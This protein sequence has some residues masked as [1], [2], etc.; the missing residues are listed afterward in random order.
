[1]EKTKG[2]KLC[3]RECNIDRESGIGF[4]GCGSKVILARAALHKWE[5]PCISGRNGS[6]TVFFSGCSLRCVFCQNYEISSCAYGKTVDDRRLAEIFLELQE[7]KANNINLVTPTHFVP[8]IISALD[9]AK[10]NGL[11]IP[12]VY[13]SSGYEKTETLAML[14]GYIDIYLPD[15]KYMSRELAKKYSHAEDYPECAATAVDEMVKQVGTPVFNRSNKLMKKGVI[16][17]HLILPGCTGDSKEIL[18]YLWGKYGD[19]IYIS[20]MNQFTPLEN[21][22][23]FPEINRK[24]TVRE[25][26]DVIR[27]AKKIGITNAFI[28]EEGTAAESFIPP[29][30]CTGL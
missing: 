18:K 4:C 27:Y 17:R 22:R 2:C 7:K 5:E 12:V 3:P 26:D 24:I 25:Y 15:F 28:Q 29:F 1:M 16:V 14:K 21:V 13:N 30:D 11:K 10:S 23:Q 19:T 6:G 9:Y 8:N 20:I